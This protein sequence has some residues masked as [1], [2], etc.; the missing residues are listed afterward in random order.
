MLNPKAKLFV[1][2]I[3]KYIKLNAH[4]PEFR[5]V[6]CG[7]TD[8]QKKHQST[9]VE[10]QRPAKHSE[11][12]PFARPLIPSSNQEPPTPI[13]IKPISLSD[14]Q[15]NSLLSNIQK[16]PDWINKR[17][18]EVHDHECL[19]P[20]TR[21]HTAGN[22]AH[23]VNRQ[24]R[25]VLSYDL[26]R[27]FD[28]TA[29]TSVPQ[30][31]QIPRADDIEALL[32]SFPGID[33]IDY[34]NIPPPCPYNE[35]DV[36][37][38]HKMHATHCRATPK[39]TAT[40]ISDCCYFKPFHYMIRYGFQAALRT[41][42]TTADIQPHSPAYI[43]LWNKDKERCSRAFSKLF[44][45]THLQ[46]ID[47]PPL[48]F[49]L[50]PVIKGKQLWRYEKFGTDFNLRLAEDITS[51]GGNDIFAD[52]KIRY[53]ALFAIG[54]IIAR[55]DFLA[56]RDITGFFNRLPAGELLR[57]LQCFQDPRSYGKTPQENNEKV[58]QGKATFLQQQTCMF[59]H[60]QLPAWASCV[61]SELAR[62][63]HENTI[64]VAGVLI[65][66]FLFH[67]PHQLGKETLEK[68]LEE[69]DALMTRLGVP[70]NNKGQ[71]PTQ[72]PVF[73]GIVINT[74]SGYM[75]VEE[76]QRQYCIQR[77]K[78]FI[79][80]QS[81][82]TK[83]LASVNGSLGWLCCVIH[84]GRCRRDLIQKAADSDST[85]IDITTTLRKR[86][87]QLY[88]WWRI[89]TKKNYRPSP[90]WFRNEHQDS[91]LVQSDA[92]G[93]AGFGFCAAGLHVTGRWSPSIHEFLRNDM[94]VKKL[95]PPTIAVLILHQILKGF[96]FC[97]GCDNSGVVF[98]INCGS[99]RNPVGRKLLE[100]SADAL[101]STHGHMLA[102]WNNREQPRAVHADLLSKILSESE[103][104]N[105]Q[106]PRQPAWIFNLFIHSIRENKTISANIRIPKLAEALPSH[107]RH[108]HTTINTQ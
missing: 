51:S 97:T 54:Q 26:Q 21:I 100:T 84:Q 7:C 41:G 61:S 5:P 27:N 62:I 39:C 48:I 72:D 87:K 105:I 77:L 91:V 33:K 38:W 12:Y 6:E 4:A 108:T 89:L 99:C 88:W 106:S 55:G 94:F 53:L 78:E 29:F 75:D 96:I 14:I 63:L 107:L 90:I 22:S 34:D 81:V 103:W 15:N 3:R 74:V 2:Y 83:D 92:S 18:H 65:D 31:N 11:R 64:R 76:E 24:L 49:P 73:S 36:E 1:P 70:P 8:H 98:R 42:C 104:Q 86:K 56:T 85:R 19:H 44:K 20:K 93:D 59:G 102:D 101:A 17:L 16:A 43:H 79:D 82:A 25:K 23:H 67:G 80:A 37:L 95:I 40:T 71:Q 13:P 60:K 69:A 35:L 47:N 45:S 30:E 9:P 66:D 10:H 32:R 52:W 68:Q 58:K 28:R 46:P 50:L 57:S